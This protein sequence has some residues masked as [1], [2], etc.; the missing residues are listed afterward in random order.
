MDH[1]DTWRMQDGGYFRRCTREIR[2]TY[3]DT[4]KHGYGFCIR[5]MQCIKNTKELKFDVCIRSVAMV[6]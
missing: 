3:W 4:R 1:V 5:I 6:V 2:Q